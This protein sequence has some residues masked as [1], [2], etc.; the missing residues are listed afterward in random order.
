VPD[1]AAGEKWLATLAP[2]VEPGL[3]AFWED[4]A[5]ATLKEERPGLPGE[6]EQATDGVPEGFAALKVK[7]VPEGSPLRPGDMILE[8]DGEPFF[9][10]ADGAAFLRDYL[11]RTRGQALHLKVRRDGQLHDVSV[12]LK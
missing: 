2:K 9:A 3:L 7:S 10:A 1:L 8:F 5:V 6:W 4:Y 12:P 11:W